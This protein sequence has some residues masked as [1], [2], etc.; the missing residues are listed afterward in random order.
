MPPYGF[1]VEFHTTPD[2]AAALTQFLRDAKTLVDAEPG[3]LT[4]FAFRTGPTSFGVFDAFPTAEDRERHLHGEVRRAIVA[5]AGELFD[6][7]PVITP[8][9]VLA[10]KLPVG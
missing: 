5:R 2:R 6:R 1:L 7:A 10:A 8:V 3:T 9:D 4:W